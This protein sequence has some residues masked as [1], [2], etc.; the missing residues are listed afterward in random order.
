MEESRETAKHVHGKIQ[1]KLKAQPV[2]EAECMRT[3]AQASTS[4]HVRWATC[5][6]GSGSSSGSTACQQWWSLHACRPHACML[7]KFV[8]VSLQ[9]PGWTG[10]T[11]D[12]LLEKTRPYLCE[13]REN[14]KRLK[15]RFALH[16]FL[17]LPMLYLT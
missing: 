11:A 15:V 6:R 9:Y 13:L 12:V 17:V 4:S 3:D 1:P 5:G 2:T 14:W 16:G 10:L 7:A 8:F